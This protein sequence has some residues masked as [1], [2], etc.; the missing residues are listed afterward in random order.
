MRIDPSFGNEASQGIGK[1]SAGPIKALSGATL[2][3]HTNVMS[4]NSNAIM[5][6]VVMIYFLVHIPDFFDE[7]LPDF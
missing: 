2:I 5:N 1:S 4:L 6:Q 3:G 7:F